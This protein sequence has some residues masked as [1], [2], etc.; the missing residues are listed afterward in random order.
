MFF[1]YA[2]LPRTADSEMTLC[3]RWVQNDGTW[4]YVRLYAQTMQGVQNFTNAEAASISG[5]SPPLPQL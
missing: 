4:S 5:A 3:D 1:R 2:L